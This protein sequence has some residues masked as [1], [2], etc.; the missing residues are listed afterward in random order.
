MSTVSHDFETVI[1][2]EVHVQLKTASKV[3]AP[4]P[5]A[6]VRDADTGALSFRADTGPNR[7]VD[8]V[9][10]GLPGAL[11]VLNKEAVEQSAKFALLTEGR[12]PDTSNWVR[13]NY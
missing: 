5:S 3:F 1:G 8:P 7:R 4:A 10:L 11:P 13:K 2:L 12:V 9:V 6:F